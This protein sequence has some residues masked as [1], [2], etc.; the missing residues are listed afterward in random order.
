MRKIALEEHFMAPKFDKYEADVEKMMTPDDY[1]EFA[2]RLPEFTELRLQTM[3]KAEIDISVLSQTSPGLQIEKDTPTAIR[4]SQEAN[5]FL[6]LQIQKHP[7]RFAGFAHLAMQDPTA[8]SK[9]LERCVIALGFKGAL[10]NGHTNGVY[11][12]DQRYIPFWESLN[13]LDVPLYLHPASSFDAPH[14]FEGHPDLM[15][16]TWGWT[17][18]T[19][20][21]ALRL[22]VSGLFDRLPNLKIILG[23]MGEALPFMLWRFDSRWQISR[24]SKKLNKSLSQYIRDNIIITTSGV[25]DNAPLLCSI[26]ALGADNVLFSTDYPFESTQIAADFIEKAPLSEDVRKKICY[27]NAQRLLKL[28]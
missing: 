2:A 6:A 26:E 20:T 5:D 9:E 21:H 19:T 23:H 1:K 27:Q 28:N 18:E 17:V 3:D 13:E 16:P 25:C 8:A 22:I 15:G 12:D 24:H 10:V 4:K 11:L 7:S 14:M